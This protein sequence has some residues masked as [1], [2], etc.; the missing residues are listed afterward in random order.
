MTNTTTQTMIG[1]EAVTPI[2][3]E[4]NLF[5]V[6]DWVSASGEVVYQDWAVKP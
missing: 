4:T 3:S 1:H 5:V 6:T 2:R